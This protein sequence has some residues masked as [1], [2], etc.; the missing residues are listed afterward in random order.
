MTESSE[1]MTI[2]RKKVRRIIALGIILLAFFQYQYNADFWAS[3]WR[4]A[5]R[6]ET[7]QLQVQGWA[8]C[9]VKVDPKIGFYLNKMND[10]EFTSLWSIQSKAYDFT[11]EDVKNSMFEHCP[12]QTLDAI[13]TEMGQYSSFHNAVEK[14]AY[15]IVL[16][17]RLQ[18]QLKFLNRDFSALKEFQK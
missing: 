18:Y 6:S 5:K 14:E 2:S 10:E 8:G 16:R 9:D 1:N 3:F 12:P 7:G 15:K 4:L 17:D 11:Y 13:D